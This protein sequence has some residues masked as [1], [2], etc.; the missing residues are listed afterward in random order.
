MS[1][2]SPFAKIENWYSVFS[3]FLVLLGI[4]FKF[5]QFLKRIPFLKSSGPQLSRGCIH[6]FSTLIFMY[7]MKHF[8]YFFSVSKKYFCTSDNNFDSFITPLIF[9]Q[10]QHPGT[11]LNVELHQLSETVIEIKIWASIDREMI[12]FYWSA[13]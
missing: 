10:I 13:E 1:F 3:T 9:H 5:G 2:L 8:I 11:L 12:V 4:C 6:F 7:V